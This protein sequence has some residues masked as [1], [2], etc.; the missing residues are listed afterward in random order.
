VSLSLEALWKM[1]EVELLAAHYDVR[2]QHAGKKFARD[3]QRARPDWQRAKAFAARRRVRAQECGRSVRG[4]GCNGR[5][6]RE[7]TRDLDPLRT[8]VD[9]I[10]MMVRLRAAFA[11]TDPKSRTTARTEKMAHSLDSGLIDQIPPGLLRLRSGRKM[12]ILPSDSERLRSQ[13]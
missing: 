7:L 6:P 13:W 9:L 2:R 1:S 10:A 3:T 12:C 11:P 8:D 5:E 4:T